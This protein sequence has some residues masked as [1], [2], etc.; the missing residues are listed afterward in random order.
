[1]GDLIFSDCMCN[2]ISGQVPEDT[3]FAL[4]NTDT[5]TVMRKVEMQGIQWGLQ[6]HKKSAESN[7]SALEPNLDA[8][9]FWVWAV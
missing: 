8:G 6:W 7:L 3:L 9:Q 2:K 1:M 4:L 5:I